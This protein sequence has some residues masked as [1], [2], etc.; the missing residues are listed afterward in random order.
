VRNDIPPRKPSTR[1]KKRSSTL[2]DSDNNPAERVA[3]FS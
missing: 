2:V 3:L 1:S